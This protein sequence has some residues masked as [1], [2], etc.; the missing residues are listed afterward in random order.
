MLDI[1][2]RNGHIID[3][4]N[5]R[6]EIGSV[7]MIGNRIVEA[8]PDAQADY[9]VDAEGCLVLPG[10]IDFH[11]HLF[12]G[13]SAHGIAPDLMA[14]H[15][16][17]SANDAGTTGA[18]NFEAFYR[19]IMTQSSLRLV[20]SL[21]LYAMGQPGYGLS[22]DLDP[23]HYPKEEIKHLINAYPD[24]I[25]SIKIRVGEEIVGDHCLDYVEGAVDYCSDLGL[26]LVVHASNLPCAADEVAKRLRPGDVFCHCFHG[27]K[28]PIVDENNQILP[29]IR[30]ARERGVLF[31]CCNGR[32]NFSCKVGAAAIQQ[33]FFPDFI[34][35][36]L[37][38]DYCN[39]N[40]FAKSLPYVMS[41]YLELGMPLYDIVHAVTARPASWLRIPDI[42]SL[43]PGTLADITIL[44]QIEA[45]PVYVDNLGDSF[46]GS[47]LLKPMMT[48][49]D[50]EIVFS[51]IDF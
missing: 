28:N 11:A 44:K 30:V 35:T 14:A 22:E 42:G 12:R 34:S 21:N 25:R 1:L 36:D 29:G 32:S 48:I 49:I 3:P 23:N 39:R 33:K 41:K 40:G 19:S 24:K 4:A 45:N 2:I 50:G 16:V 38:P 27:K 9:V 37:I 15:G 10:L 47:Q 51:Q 17:T 46:Q 20:A 6:D 18:A 7:G 26:P 13:G 31:D 8:M 5:S 43:T